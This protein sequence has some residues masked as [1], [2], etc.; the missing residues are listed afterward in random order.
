MIYDYNIIKGEKN[1]MAGSF[2]ELLRF[3]IATY[4]F[5]QSEDDDSDTCDAFINFINMP[6]NDTTDFSESGKDDIFSALMLNTMGTVNDFMNNNPD[7]ENDMK[8]EIEVENEVGTISQDDKDQ[9]KEIGN[10]STTY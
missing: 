10:K 2:M 7:T 8:T 3:P 4:S 1:N 5:T 6:Q 9:S